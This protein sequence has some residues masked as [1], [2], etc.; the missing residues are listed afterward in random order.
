MTL[1]SLAKNVN[2]SLD[3]RRRCFPAKHLFF[4]GCTKT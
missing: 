4:M 2:A 3:V 1:E